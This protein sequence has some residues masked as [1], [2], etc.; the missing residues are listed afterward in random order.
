MCVS[1][2]ISTLISTSSAL[3]RSQGE[4]ELLTPCVPPY[5]GLRG[6][7]GARRDWSTN[8]VWQAGV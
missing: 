1:F 5:G 8:L 7:G 6:E 4:L 3:R 2:P